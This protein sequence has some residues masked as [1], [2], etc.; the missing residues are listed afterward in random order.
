MPDIT[1]INDNDEVLGY[2]EKYSAHMNPVHLH[3]AISVVIINPVTNK[4][5]L[6]CR[7]KD[8][9]TWPLYWSNACCTHPF[10]DESYKAAAE[11]RLTEEM[12]FS[13]SLDE[14]F[15]FSYSAEYDETWGENELDV[16]F[17]GQYAGNVSPD[18]NEVDAYKWLD[19]EELAQA[20]NKGMKI[21]PW[22]EII[23]KHWA[24]GFK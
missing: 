24:T 16:V 19:Q 23:L 22:F 7:G 4:M 17:M 12:G 15:R 6:Q 11:R 1:L 2:R 8:K 3:R 9:P 13:T 5:L 21:T 18:P 10:P 20:I 14:I